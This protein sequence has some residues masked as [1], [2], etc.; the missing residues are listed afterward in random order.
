MEVGNYGLTDW[1]I[2]FDIMYSNDNLLIN[3]SK[4]LWY[5]TFS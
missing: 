1:L 4:I 2:K 5:I 3:N